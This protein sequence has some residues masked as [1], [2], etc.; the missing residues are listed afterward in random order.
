MRVELG[1]K[2][3]TVYAGFWIGESNSM[4][5]AAQIKLIPSISLHQKENLTFL[6]LFREIKEIHW[7]DLV[8]WKKYY[9]SIYR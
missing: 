8:E 9:N 6:F 5:A 3:I 7:F 2:P 4:E 1:S